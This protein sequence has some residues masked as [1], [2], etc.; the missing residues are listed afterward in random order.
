ML[1]RFKCHSLFPKKKLSFCCR[2]NNGTKTKERSQ[3]TKHESIG[4][5]VY[6][7]RP[8]ERSSLFQNCVECLT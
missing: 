5:A 2:F 7:E 3:Q 1:F 4:K 6:A 8:N